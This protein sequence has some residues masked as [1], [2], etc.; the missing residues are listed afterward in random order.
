MKKVSVIVP[1]Y[2]AKSYVKPCVDAL[3]RQGICED[4]LEILLVDDKSPDDTYEYTKNLFKDSKAVRV[5]EQ[6]ENGGPGKAR[7]RG[8]L[9]ATGKYICFAD[10]D[11]MYTDNA[12]SRMVDIAEEKNADVVHTNGVCFTVANPLPDDLSTLTDDNIVDFLFIK[13]KTIDKN[14]KTPYEAESIE[15]KMDAWYSHEYHWNVWGKLYKR[16]FLENNNIKFLNMRIGEDCIFVMKCVLSANKYVLVNDFSYIYRIGEPE[17]ISR[18]K[19]NPKVFINAQRA[20]FEVEKV[21]DDEF[22][23]IPYLK[24]HPEE[25]EKLKKMEIDNIEGPY[26]VAKFH[27]IG[28]QALSENE[29]VIAAF[30]EYHGDKA[31]D[32]ME[33][34]FD[35]YEKITEYPNADGFTSYE[36][37][38]GIKDKIGNN[39]ISYG[40]LSN[41]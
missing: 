17:S 19:G 41:K 21:F 1:I 13:D 20:I 39:N 18:G 12:L 2:K 36:M 30:V 8:L 35:R 23:N 7:N 34:L 6:E 25:M 16:E 15:K 33:M 24:D 9:E 10:V 28:R 26:V 14:D 22:K 37:W 40:E 29:D 31:K 3:L 27:E 4:E 5:I 32:K 11:D 38:K